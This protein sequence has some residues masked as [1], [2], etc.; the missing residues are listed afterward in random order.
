M[1]RRI[2]GF[3]SAIVMLG[4]TVLA[5]LGVGAATAQAAVQQPAFEC[6]GN[7]VCLF[8]GAKLNGSEQTIVP[9]DFH[10]WTSTY[11]AESG[12]KKVHAGS[13]HNNT[14]WII[15]VYAIDNQARHCYNSGKRPVL[16]GLY[17]YIYV[18]TNVRNCAGQTIPEPLP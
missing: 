5:A 16:N 1:K 17:G 6:P 14:S 4:G 15:W 7:S 9:N 10:R 13:A 8:S 12:G 2:I 3:A 18:E 11:V